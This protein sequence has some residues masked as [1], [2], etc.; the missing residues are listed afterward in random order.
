M[1]AA[2]YRSPPAIPT[3]TTFVEGST[4]TAR[5]LRSFVAYERRLLEL[6]VRAAHD[7]WGTAAGFDVGVSDAQTHV[8][9]APGV[10][11]DCSGAALVL[12]RP[13][14]VEVPPWPGTSRVLE[15]YVRRAEADP[16]ATPAAICDGATAI[17]PPVA[18]H[19]VARYAGSRY[20][21]PE[22]L[23]FGADVPLARFLQTAGGLGGP[24]L[25]IRRMTRSTAQSRVVSGHVQGSALN[26]VNWANSLRARIDMPNAKFT[27]PPQVF[28]TFRDL[29]AYDADVPGP[30]A[31]VYLTQ[32]TWFRIQLRYATRLLV[33]WWVLSNT[34]LV[35]LNAATLSWT[36]VEAGPSRRIPFDLV[37]ALLERGGFAELGRWTNAIAQFGAT[38]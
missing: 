29:T 14:F 8:V 13:A 18:L 28:V 16:C 15:L 19:W 17:A 4:L 7:V 23:N 32:T 37:A 12:A 6:H 33:N 31:F 21:V 10:A 36:A 27:T 1:T 3:R 24:D 11:F 2:G 9:V 38:P 25:R 22:D 26:W 20:L 5:D 34:A 35:K 30:L